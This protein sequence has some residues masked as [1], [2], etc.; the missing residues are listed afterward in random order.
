MD[1]EDREDTDNQPWK[2]ARPILVITGHKGHFVD[3][4]PH[5]IYHATITS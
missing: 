3:F 2:M 5:R 4:V 1:N